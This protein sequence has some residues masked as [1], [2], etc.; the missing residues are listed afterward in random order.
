MTIWRDGHEHYVEFKDGVAVEPLK[1]VAD[2]EE[3]KTGTEVTFFPS[4][5]IFSNIEFDYTTLERTIREKAFL[6]S[7]VRIELKDLRNEEEIKDNTF[8][9]EGGL[10]EF[11]ISLIKNGII[12]RAALLA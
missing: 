2:C 5:E 7:G 6:N 1:V 12:N 9:Y 10:V 8:H 4:S 3:S 11:V